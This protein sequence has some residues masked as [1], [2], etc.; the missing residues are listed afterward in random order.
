MTF[1]RVLLLDGAWHLLPVDSFRQ[2]FYP[3]DDDSWIAQDLP[4]HW[5]QHP[6]LERY[7]GN[8]VYRKRFALAAS[9]AD[10]ATGPQSPAAPPQRYWLRLNGVFYWSQ[11]Y[12]NG[13][14]LGRHAGYFMAQEH[15][16][17]QWVAAEN[18][19]VVEVACPEEH[20]QLGKRLITGVFSHWDCLDP[21]TN[22]GGIWL[23][24]ELIATG[25]T[26]IN[27]VLL[28]ADI[29]D[30]IGRVHYRATLDAAQAGP[31]TLRWTFAPKNFA[32]EIQVIEQQ[33]TLA[34]GTQ[35]VAG[36]LDIRDP[37]LWWTHDL[38]H[39]NLYQVSL[40]LLDDAGVSDAHQLTY[41]FRHFSMRNWIP[42]LN[43][44]RLFAKG[45][46]YAPG[47]T[48]IATMTP[49]RY[50]EDLRLARECHMNMLRVHA[51]VEHPAFYEAADAAGV[52][53]WQDFP[54]Q[55]LYRRSILPEARRQARAMVRQLYNHPALAIWCMHNEPIYVADTKD[56]RIRTALRTYAS[57][58]I[59]SWSRNV[60]D[61]Q[62]KQI[63]QAEDP[64]RPVVRASG[65]YAVPLFH[66]GT[67]SH[68]YYGW[69]SKVYGPLRSWEPLARH[70]PNI[71]RF[72]TEFG[73]QSFPNLA[74]CLKFM[75]ADVALIDWDYMTMR[76][77]FQ[78]S[79]MDHSLDWRS[80][81]MLEGLIALT[82][83][84]QVEV[85][86]FYI[87]RLRYAKYRP[88]GGILP[89]MFHDPN[90]AISFSILDYWRVPKR[91]YAALRLAFSP[92]YVFT[93]LARD[94]SPV[95]TPIDL[96]IY[97][98][99]DA[100]R[101]VPVEIVARLLAPDQTE[102]ARVARSL[103]LPAD[104]MAMEVE[105]LRLTPMTPG[106]YRLALS[107]C[108]QEGNAIANEY[109]IVVAPQPNVRQARTPLRP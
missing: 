78:P 72:V 51:H 48:R 43:G 50:A 5:Q 108:D 82:Q 104:C 103:T 10:A 61:T 32:G 2:G 14:D 97:V 46:N 55:W 102:L 24:V 86:R 62:L 96:P 36:R 57:V 58:F 81:R 101:A 76:H 3:L 91:S 109:M 94:R 53:L 35:E 29:S 34:Q 19:L 54:L 105:R 16:V 47:D 69:Y 71:I 18:T 73:A 84:Y 74:S 21:A 106:E 13:V 87:D 63:A 64:T 30:Q 38:G 12:F 25:A 41:G 68:F 27:E 99:N 98:V 33:R 95:A 67:D 20:N 17:T 75:D 9:I 44:V 22:P 70:F 39:P 1:P 23:P 15:E 80:V 49:E 66:A 89:F 100:H 11:P 92:Q 26:R 4:A 65:E 31:A 37:Q 60:M 28:D 7:A 56:E 59:W 8:M 42:H 45:N 93:L 77:Q 83:D 107:L 40:E 85:N 52:L 6:L 88:T 90:P 79:I